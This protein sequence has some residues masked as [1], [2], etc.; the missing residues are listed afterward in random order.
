MIAITRQVASPHSHRSLWNGF[1]L[2]E[3]VVAIAIIL[4]L[5]A[6]AIPNLLRA[7]MAAN[8]ASTVSSVRTINAAEVSYYSMFGAYAPN[9]ASLGGAAPC[10]PTRGSACLIDDKLANATAG[11]GK[12]GYLFF[13]EGSGDGSQYVV[14][15]WPVTPNTTGT[16]SFCST[17]DAVVR[18]NSS[19]GMIEDREACLALPAI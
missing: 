17:E 3:L 15:A 11:T 12:T 10:S 13:V 9:L 1:T 8:E 16:R 2:I 5:A 4:T 14:K 19:G 18:V 6:I 7:R